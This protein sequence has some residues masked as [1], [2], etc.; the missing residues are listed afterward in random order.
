MRVLLPIAFAMP[1]LGALLQDDAPAPAAATAQRSDPD[2]VYFEERVQPLLVNSCAIT[3]CHDQPGAGRLILERPDFTGRV[4][5]EGTAKN[6]ATALQFVKFDAPLESRLLLKPLIKRD[7]GLDHSG[8]HYDFSKKSE[9][10]RILSEWIEGVELHDVPPI[11]DAGPTIS[12]KVAQRIELDGEG[13]RE[14]RGLPLRYAWSI[15]SHPDGSAPLLKDSD[16]ARPEFRGDKEG[17]YTLA[18]VVD[19]GTLS[20]EPDTVTITLD[21]LPIVV[22]DAERFRAADGFH[23]V[24]DAAASGGLAI[25]VGQEFAARGEAT[26]SF[27]FVV[28]EGGAYRLFARVAPRSTA[29]QPLAFA[30]DDEPARNLEVA[31]EPGYRLAQVEGGGVEGRLAGAA[32]ELESGTGAIR[33]ARLVLRGSGKSP[34][35]GVLD[36]RAKVASVRVLGRADEGASLWVLSALGADG[37]ARAAGYD[38]ANDRFVVGTWTNGRVDVLAEA[39]AGLRKDGAA[40]VAC[41][42]ELAE[43]SAFLVLGEGRVLNAEF[44]APAASDRIALATDGVVAIEA[45]RVSQGATELAARTF[46]RDERAPGV[47]AAGAHTLTVRATTAE[48]P[49]LDELVFVRADIASGAAGV[50]DAKRK[51]T[52]ALYFDLVGR[53]PL[54]VEQM[55]GVGLERDALATRLIGSLEFYEHWYEDELFFYLLLDNFRPRTP[56]MQAMPARLAN[57]TLDIRAATQE[58]VISQAFNLR[59]PGNDTF[60]SV[61]LEQLLGI[62]VQDEPKL[63][64]AGKKMYDGYVATLFGQQGRSQS[65]FV[66]IV[67]E[68]PAFARVFLARAYERLLRAPPQKAELETWAKRFEADPR[69]YTQLVREWVASAAYA[70]VSRSARAKTDH[71]FIRSVFVDLLGRKPTFEE[72][73]NFRTALQA[74]ADSRPLRAVLARVMVDSGQVALPSKAGLDAGAFAG[75]QFLRFL[76]RKPDAQETEIFTKAMSDPQAEPKLVLLALLSSQEYQSY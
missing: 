13:S 57:G 21:A 70:Q 30:I 49:R 68:Q 62:V 52:R 36:A 22:L 23:A 61:V 17:S 60:V 47:L 55:M 65:D 31:P 8:H 4:S 14:R 45:Y 29:V 71:M 32:L 58:V 51:E 26:A 3:G 39:P 63:L 69:V 19:N 11:A 46:E 12:A 67:L 38:G 48:A 28:P 16:T 33:D 10:F 42:V 75:E 53:P 7:G 35:I 66:R 72:F 27:E 20:S 73:R 2:P 5:T 40:D 59:N 6:L 50:S 64:D 25:D 76:G 56:Q 15:V 43:R 54:A 9:K 34:A 37:A 41:Q 18:L 74:L 24:R 1:C 44:D